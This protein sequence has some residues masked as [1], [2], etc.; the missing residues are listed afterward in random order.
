MMRSPFAALAAISILV[1]TGCSSSTEAEYPL[2]GLQEYEAADEIAA[3]LNAGGFECA[4]YERRTGGLNSASSGNCWHPNDETGKDQEIIVM[5][6][7]TE[8]DQKRQAQFYRD[9]AELF[10]DGTGGFVEGGNWMVNC[11]NKPVCAGVEG[12]LGG[13]TETASLF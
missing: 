2:S 3:D 1:L 11:G 5:I 13:R 7:N 6:F 4:N 10:D 9:M 12:V 8:S